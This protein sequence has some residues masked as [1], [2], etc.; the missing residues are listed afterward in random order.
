MAGT[1]EPIKVLT[2]AGS[3]SGGAAGLQCDLKTF[4]ALGVY[5]MSVVTAVTAQNSVEVRA[6]HYLPADFVAQQMDAVLSDYGAA[7]AKTGLIGRAELAAVVADR[8]K[9]YTVPALVIDPVLVNHR[10]RPLFG[11]EMAAAYRQH[12]LPLATVAT[13]NRWEAA[14]LADWEVGAVQTVAQMAEAAR[15]I[16]AL[17]PRWALVKGG[18]E[19]DEMVDVLFDGRRVIFFRSPW[20]DT[21]NT[22]GSGDMLSAALCAGLGQGLDVMEAVERARQMTAAGIE[23]AAGW[24]LGTGHGPVSPW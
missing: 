5:G 9:A 1:A 14:L 7:A 8:L 10:G 24:R 18:R 20:I 19:G 2:I 22:H 11:E 12:L 6:V 17:G 16:Q 4:T 15:A 21:A 3:D 23:R 13:P